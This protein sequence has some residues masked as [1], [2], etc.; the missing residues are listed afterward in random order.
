M[1]HVKGRPTPLRRW[2]GRVKYWDGAAG[3][4]HQVGVFGEY[5]VYGHGYRARR[6]RGRST[7]VHVPVELQPRVRGGVIEL[8][9]TVLIRRS[10][11]TVVKLSSANYLDFGVIGGDAVPHESVG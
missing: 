2:Q 11:P 4:Q 3:S 8:V 9:S 5:A 6:A 7:N 1:D 10:A